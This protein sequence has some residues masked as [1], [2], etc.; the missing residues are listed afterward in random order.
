MN[1]GKVVLGV[2]AGLAA[3]AVLGILFAPDKGTMTRKKI[4]A[5]GD[6]TIDE[7]KEKFEEVKTDSKHVAA[8]V[9]TDS[10]NLAKEAK[11]SVMDGKH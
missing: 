11:E 1:N 8:E 2:L 6:D 9:K 7:L 4:I 5:K 3:G 10:K